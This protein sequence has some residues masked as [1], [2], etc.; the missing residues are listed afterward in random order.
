MRAAIENDRGC[1]MRLHV[2]S[3]T[4]INTYLCNG[5]A[6]CID[7]NLYVGGRC[8]FT[9]SNYCPMCVKISDGVSGCI[10]ATLYCRIKLNM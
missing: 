10:D 4:Y 2:D 8:Y 9:I 6:V 1:E 5:I 7:S 3:V